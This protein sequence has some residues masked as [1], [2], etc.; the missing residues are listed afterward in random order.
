MAEL[1]PVTAQELEQEPMPEDEK[2]FIKEI[3]RRVPSASLWRKDGK[4]MLRG[5]SLKSST[6]GSA[7]TSS[8]RRRPTAAAWSAPS[9][10]SDVQVRIT[11]ER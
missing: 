10:D 1:Q 9:S 7:R 2:K 4:L 8:T 6:A 5:I 3:L 11:E